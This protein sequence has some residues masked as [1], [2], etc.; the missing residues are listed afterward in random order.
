M[1]NVADISLTIRYTGR[2]NESITVLTLPTLDV[3][4]LL[5]C[6][7]EKLQLIVVLEIEI[8]KPK[9]KSEWTFI[10]GCLNSCSNITQSPR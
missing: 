1:G 5:F 2:K 10:H 8:M 6:G 7:I 3:S 9:N 4:S